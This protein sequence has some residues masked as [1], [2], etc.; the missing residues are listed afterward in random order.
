MDRA[1]EWFVAITGFIIGL[2]HVIRPND[3]ADFFRRLHSWGRAGAFVNGALS[4]AAGA[5]IAVGHASWDWPGTPLT[6]F[7]WLLIAKAALCFLA[8]DAAKRSMARGVASPRSFV[9]A[10]VMLLAVA[11]WACYL[12]VAPDN[13]FD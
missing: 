4:L 3:W 11:G 13:G 9:I 6:A 7:G 2:S 10:G 12:L 1:V 5:I 8:P